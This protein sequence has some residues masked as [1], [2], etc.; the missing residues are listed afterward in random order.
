[1]K[2]S[3]QILCAIAVSG[4]VSIA[5]PMV[6]G[7]EIGLFQAGFA[8]K[9]GEGAPSEV[10]LLPWNDGHEIA[11]RQPLPA[12]R[13]WDGRYRWYGKSDANLRICGNYNNWE[14]GVPGVLSA[15]SKNL[16][17]F[18]Y[19][20]Q[21]TVRNERR[22][23]FVD[24]KAILTC[25]NWI[26]DHVHHMKAFRHWECKLGSFLDFVI[27]H[28]RGDG[29]FYELFKQMDDI[30]WLFVDKSNYVLFPEDH[31]SLVRLEIE[32]D[33]EYLVVEGAHHYYQA[34]GDDA[35]LRKVLP[36][37]EKSIDY[38]TSDPKRWD[39][40]H[41]LVKRAYTIDTWD[42]V[43]GRNAVSYLNRIIT[44]KTQMCVMHGDNSGVVQAMLQ[45][46]WFNERLGD[47]E[48]AAAWRKRAKALRDAMFKHLW[49]GTFFCHQLPL[50]V[51][52]VDAHERERLSLSSTYDMNR[53]FMTLD[54]RRSV[55]G[56]YSRRR[57][58]TK[59]FA[60]WFTVDPPYVRGFG[61]PG[62]YVNGAIAPFVAG[63]L[64]K[65]AFESGYEEY[66]W[67]ILERL[68]K[69]CERDGG[70]FFLYDPMTQKEQ[71]G[72]P[73]GWG[74][75]AL[76]SAIDEGLAG[77]KDAGT[78]Y[79]VIDFSPRWTVTP[80][81]EIR[82]FTGY[83][84][85]DAFVEVRHVRNGKGLRYRVKSPAKEIRAHILLPKGKTAAKVLVDGREAEFKSVFVAESPYVDLSVRP[86][87]GVVDI[88]ILYK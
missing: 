71:A 86:A 38:M 49:N 46:A 60:E 57:Q 65:A 19:K 18:M 76:L 22:Y 73:K 2:N 27:D 78:R 44:P 7:A 43:Q 5:S 58:T 28:Q 70:T 80:H 10:E 84:I 52:P 72:G 82:Y 32:A 34:T 61:A 63:E 48:K 66:G 64:A 23:V 56:E 39:A 42:G 62:G 35:W 21:E 68:R 36:R 79:D 47:A 31:Q 25:H 59:A 12:M 53:G 51:A 3:M 29:Q 85:S 24:G 87:S 83:E 40:V 50:N 55:I 15:Q 20:L 14:L 74:A 77:V 8:V 9:A 16:G 13:E 69:M 54:E 88:E 33:V 11:F 6:Y 67:D 30:H 17:E 41:G 4:L 45:L 26:R 75:A 1:M 81:E 37:L